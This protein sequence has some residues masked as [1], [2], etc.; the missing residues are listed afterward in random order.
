MCIDLDTLYLKRLHAHMTPNMYRSECD[1]WTGWLLNCSFHKQVKIVTEELQDWGLDVTVLEDTSPSDT[2]QENADL[3][4]RCG[5][6]KKTCYQLL[7]KAVFKDNTKVEHTNPPTLTIHFNLPQDP[8]AFG[9]RQSRFH[10]QSKPGIAISLV[11]DADW[12]QLIT[13]ERLCETDI[14]PLP[15]NFAIFC[16]KIWWHDQGTWKSLIVVQPCRLNIK[17]WNESHNSDTAASTLCTMWNRIESVVWAAPPTTTE[18]SWRDTYSS[19]DNSVQCT[20]VHHDLMQN[21]FVIVLS[22]RYVCALLWNSWKARA[23]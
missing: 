21:C 19:I 20:P 17:L 15:L 18:Y 11:T 12:D 10:L 2:S 23:A 6:A 4:Q 13:I 1:E 22:V 7:A 9:Q 14:E 8:M 5:T 3:T 16:P